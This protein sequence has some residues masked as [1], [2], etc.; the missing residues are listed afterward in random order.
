MVDRTDK[1]PNLS[2]P[3]SAAAMRRQDGTYQTLGWPEAQFSLPPR[4]DR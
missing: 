3:L 2:F 1:V 4:A